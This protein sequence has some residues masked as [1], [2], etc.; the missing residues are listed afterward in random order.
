L[1]AVEVVQSDF[2]D[3]SGAQPKSEDE[4]KDE[5]VFWCFSAGKE[6]A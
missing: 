5:A 2:S 3:F 1:V 6:L 4:A